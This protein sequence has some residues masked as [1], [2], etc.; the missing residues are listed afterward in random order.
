MRSAG[1]PACPSV[2]AMPPPHSSVNVAPA[3]AHMAAS[4]A[5]WGSPAAALPLEHRRLITASGLRQP[6]RPVAR[7]CWHP[8]M[9]SPVWELRRRAGCAR[10]PGMTQPFGRPA[11]D[12]AVLCLGANTAACMAAWGASKAA[13]SLLGPAPP[14][15]HPLVTASSVWLVSTALRSGGA[16]ASRDGAPS[17]S[18][19][20]R[21]GSCGS[22]QAA[23]LQ[24]AL[25]AGEADRHATHAMP[26]THL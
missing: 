5:H 2:T 7:H 19:A 15:L 21:G 20:G 4:L 13:P 14:R 24:L 6:A 18:A 16:A 22:A 25:N 10:I 9:L 3:S 11:P 12:D 8:M 23:C 1:T 17:P 26:S